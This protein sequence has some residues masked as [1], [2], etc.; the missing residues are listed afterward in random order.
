MGKWEMVK[1]GEIGLFQTGGTP[2]RSRPDYFYGTIPW[3]TT[4]ALGVTYIDD[5]D[6]NAF[7]SEEGITNS[8]TKIIPAKSLMIGIR[9]GVGKASINTV[10]MCTNQDIVSISNVDTSKISLEYLH[11]YIAT[12]QRY[13]DLRKRGATIQGIKME[14]LKEMLLP[15]PPLEVQRRIADI[16]DCA[17]VLIEKRK[18]QID[19][20]EL[21]IKSQFIEMFG[22]PVTNPRGWEAKKLG[23]VINTGPQNGLYK[24]A[25]SY[26]TDMSG[27]P[28]LRIDNFYDGEITDI[29]ALKR[30]NCT[31]KEIEVYGLHEND[32]VINRV[33]SIKYL[34]KCAH[35]TGLLEKTVFES[36][37]MRFSIDTAVL[38]PLY[39]VKFL[40]LPY[41]YN[42]IISHAKKAVNQ[43]SINQS[44]VQDFNLLI[45]P[46]AFQIEFSDFA[47][48][49]EAQKTQLEKSL[50]LLELDYKS[51]S[52]KCFK[53]EIF[54]E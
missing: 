46:L 35:I 23:S 1:L 18:A 3:I 26:V 25:D 28:I 11:K 50:V 31:A 2:T 41:V 38:D 19:K 34:G 16:L 10:P 47:T 40:C 17:S 39:T 4:P 42:Q 43:A 12:K 29:K 30:L 15:L 13:L 53:G 37:M 14:V 20:L 33:N 6:A 48:R 36:N 8:A 9:V 27:T 21:L 49:I 32:I 24:P 5:S 45:P 22:D 7:L 51:L 44:D 54:N 52:Q